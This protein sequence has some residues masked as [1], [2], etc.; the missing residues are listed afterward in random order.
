MH[1]NNNIVVYKCTGL[2]SKFTSCIYLYYYNYTFK[3]HSYRYIL[4]SKKIYVI[5]IHFK[6][7]DF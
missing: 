2:Y 1:D 6:I 7:Y 5:N 4:Y 3:I